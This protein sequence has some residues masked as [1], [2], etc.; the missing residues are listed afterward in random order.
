MAPLTALLKGGPKKL[1]WTPGDEE[2]FEHHK[3]TFT[4][5]SVLKHPDLS[6]QFTMD[7]DTSDMGVGA[8]LFRQFRDK[9]KFHPVT[10]FSRNTPGSTQPFVIFTDHKN[11]EYL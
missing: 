5:A 6:R 4:K 8:I 3:K 11:L 7:V 2:A 9:P 1:S 10:F